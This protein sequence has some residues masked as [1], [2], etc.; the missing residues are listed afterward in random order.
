MKKLSAWSVALLTFLFSLSALAWTPPPAPTDGFI[1][2]QA[3]VLNASELS[4][5][6]AKLA[7]INTETANEIAVLV[8]KSLEGDSIE[9]AANATFKAWGVGKK[10]KD[11]GVLLMISVSD[12][13]MRIE[14]GKGVEGEL[15][16]LQSNDILN[17]KIRPKLKQKDFAGGIDAGITGIQQVLES[18]KQGGPG[19]PAAPVSPTASGDNT[20]VIVLICLGGLFLLFLFWVAKRSGGSGGGRGG[21]S[22]GFFSGTG[23]YGGS[24]GGSSSSSSS[25]FG[26]GDSGGGGSSSDW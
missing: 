4:N 9:D 14:T 22:G 1:L 2:D 11:N 7:K 25:S 6:K 26:G 8:I 17:N 21:G 23:G 13:K 15:T 16:D 19:G 24:S 18:R 20:L 3:G 12:R 10:G 5:L